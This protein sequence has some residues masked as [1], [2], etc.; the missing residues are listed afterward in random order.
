MSRLGMPVSDT[1]TLRST[2]KSTRPEMGHAPVR[3]VG[4]DEWAW[5]K[6]F[7]YGTIMVDLE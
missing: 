3:V 6:G 5:R 4:V 7:N 1:T 2:K